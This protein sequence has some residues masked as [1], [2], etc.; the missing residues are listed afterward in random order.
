[1]RTFL[2][3]LYNAFPPAMLISVL[4]FKITWLE[5]QLNMGWLFFAFWGFLTAIL[6]AGE[7]FF[8]LLSKFF[9]VKGTGA[10]LLVCFAVCWVSLGWRRLE[11]VPASIIRE[12]ILM[13]RIPFRAINACVGA[14]LI[15]GWLAIFIAEKRKSEEKKNNGNL[16]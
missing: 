6:A 10:N 13:T 4:M 11:V 8:S 16:L 1:M 14:V 12:G 3:A 15:L 5:M 2:K 7:R 9:S